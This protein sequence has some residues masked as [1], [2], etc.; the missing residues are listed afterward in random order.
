MYTVVLSRDLGTI[1]AKQD[2][3]IRDRR[4]LE[5]VCIEGEAVAGRGEEAPGSW[6]EAWPVSQP[7]VPAS[8]A[9]CSLSLVER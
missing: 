8:A 7:E 2:L 5:E 1:V 9:S 6:G 4:W 3:H